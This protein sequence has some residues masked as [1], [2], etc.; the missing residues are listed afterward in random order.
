MSSGLVAPAQTLECHPRCSSRNMS[1][2]IDYRPGGV[3]YIMR[4]YVSYEGNLFCY[5]DDVA[6][7]M[8]MKGMT[9]V[10]RWVRSHAIML[11]KDIFPYPQ[12]WGDRRVIPYRHALRDFLSAEE[13][14]HARNLGKLLS[15][16]DTPVKCHQVN[17]DIFAL[18]L[19]YTIRIRNDYEPDEEFTEPLDTWI[20]H[21]RFR[22]VCKMYLRRLRSMS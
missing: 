2:I 18:I 7:I 15:R 22:A 8:G 19:Q 16:P 9:Q 11:L 20:R 4:V 6:V 1:F 13:N 12:D 10:K 14:S 21:F 17:T 3:F 5:A